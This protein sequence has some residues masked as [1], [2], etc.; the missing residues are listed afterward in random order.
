[1]KRWLAAVCLVLLLAACENGAEPVESSNTAPDPTVIIAEASVDYDGDGA[2]EMLY[3]RMVDGEFVDDQEPGPFMGKHW[4]GEFRLEFVS[5]DKLLLHTLDLNPTFGEEE[6]MFSPDRE[7]DI[8]FEDYNGDGFLDFS[9]GQYATSN[10]FVYNLYSLMP[11]GIAVIHSGL[12]TAGGGYSHHYEKAGNTSFR[13]RYYDNSIGEFVSTLFTWQGDQFVRTECEGCGMTV[14]EE[15]QAPV[16][17]ISEDTPKDLQLEVVR[18]EDGFRIVAAGDVLV[19]QTLI[20]PPI[21]GSSYAVHI[22]RSTFGIGQFRRDA[23]VVHPDTGSFAVYPMYDVLV[24]DI[25]GPDSFAI[26]YGFVDERH[27]VYVSVV[28]DDMREAGFYYRI[29]QMDITN[30]EV[31]VL[32]PE[33]IDAPTE[34]HFAPGWLNEAKDTLVLNSYGTGKLWAHNLVEGTVVMPDYNFEHEW[35]FYLTKE[36]P[37]GERFWYTNYRLQEYR[38]YDKKGKLLSRAAFT[39]GLD[40]YPAFLWSPDSRYSAYHDTRDHDQAHIL[41]DNGEVYTIAPQRIQFFDADGKEL[42]TVETEQDAG[43]YIELSGWLDSASGIALLHEYE[44][45]RGEGPPQKVRSQYMLLDIASGET[46]EVEVAPNIAE[47]DH[48]TPV[49]LGSFDSGIY[50]LDPDL[51]LVSVLADRGRW[52]SSQGDS[53][54]AWTVENYDTGVTTLYELDPATETVHEQGFKKNHRLMQRLGDDWL[55]WEDMSYTRKE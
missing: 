54:L 25:Y 34:D 48:L 40:Q 41:D 46:T 50:V 39:E 27:L 47:L 1:M 11:D 52:L 43:R 2:E 28:N 35:P 20:S 44:I 45:E 17:Q 12:F 6:L 21:D 3:V 5:N 15:V 49:R 14:P 24:D 32:I 36:A 37:N 30:G 4:V 16:E 29:E 55:V 26:A 42:R 31:T 51:L 8:A 18:T 33:I 23:V 10:G 38:L 9:I 13:N 19:G 53:R 7:F 22:V